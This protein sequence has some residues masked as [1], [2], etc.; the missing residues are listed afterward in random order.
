[1]AAARTKAA[2]LLEGHK[3]MALPVQK[4]DRKIFRARFIGFN[5]DAAGNACLELRR[6]A[7][8][9]FVMKAE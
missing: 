3:S 6:L 8:D 4:A 2:G 7:I 1:M 9:C 5:E